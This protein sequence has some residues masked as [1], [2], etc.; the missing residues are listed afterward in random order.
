MF[1]V[2]LAVW[3]GFFV[4]LSGSVLLSFVGY[5]GRR[6]VLLSFVDE[7]GLFVGFSCIFADIFVTLW[8]N[9]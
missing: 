7:I 8:Y 6:L 5:G 1:F 2:R 9:K 3:P 4:S